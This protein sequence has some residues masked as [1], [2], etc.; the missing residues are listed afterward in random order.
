[1]YINMSIYVIHIENIRLIY[2]NEE[3]YLRKGLVL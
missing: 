3:K 1:M 2:Y